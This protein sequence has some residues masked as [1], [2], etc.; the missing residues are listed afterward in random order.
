MPRASSGWPVVKQQQQQQQQQQ[1]TWTAFTTTSA[2]RPTLYH[3]TPT[4]T[5][6]RGAFAE[7]PPLA[8]NI[9]IPCAQEKPWQ[10]QLQQQPFSPSCT[11]GKS[12]Q[13]ALPQQPATGGT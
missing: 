2:S 4:C 10:K 5:A 8:K 13:R 7:S 12:Q 3:C 6:H 11:V 9:K 1:H